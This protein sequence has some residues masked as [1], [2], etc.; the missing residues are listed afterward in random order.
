MARK[1]QRGNLTLKKRVNGPD[2]WEF[3]WRDAS[4]RQRSKLIG[5]TEKLLSEREAQ[6]AADALR[7]EINSEL[8]K[9]VPIAVSALVERYL[10]DAVEMGRLAYSTQKSYKSFLNVWIKHQWGQHT[11]EQVRTMAVEQWLRDLK[12]APK[13]KLH[14]RNVLHVLFECAVRWE[15]IEQ[16]PITRV[17]QGG[18]RRA[19]PDVLTPSEFRALLAELTAEPYRMMVILAG[20]LGLA[21]SEF[22]GLKWADISWDAAVLSVQRGVVHCHV[23]NP[24]TVARRKPIPL[25]PELLTVLRGHRERAAYQ[26]DS[27]WVFASPYKRGA[28]PYWPDSA[29]QDFVKP[30]V[31]RAGITKRVGWHTF[32]HSYSCLLRA[33]HTDVKVQQELLRHSNIATTMNVYTQAVSD[34]KRAAHGQVVGQLLAV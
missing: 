26:A 33:N 31:T 9:A 2:V 10:N 1:Y 29:L 15:L 25:A 28:E 12:L 19:E 30:A 20:C 3:R 34:Q 14:I 4:G 13:T 18:A 8:P 7:L 6:C 17:R 27:D 5:T 21:R 24:K 22:V 11:L 32:R 23:G 16:N